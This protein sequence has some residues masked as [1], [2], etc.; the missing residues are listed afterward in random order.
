M[1]IAFDTSAKATTAVG[2]SLTYSI[3]IGSGSD[4]LLLVGATANDGDYVTG[5]TANGKAMT[6]VK[7]QAR[8]DSVSHFYVYGL[9]NPDSGTQNIVVSYSTN[10]T[11]ASGAAAYTGVAQ[12]SYAD[13]TFGGG[14]FNNSVTTQN[15]TATANVSGDWVFLWSYANTTTEHTT[16]DMTNRQWITGSN[17]TVADSNGTVSVGSNNY[18]ITYTPNNGS[19]SNYVGVVFSP[20]AAAGPANLKTWNGVAKASIKTINSVALGS[21]KSVNGI[22]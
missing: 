16:S 21:I 12:T 7:K 11:C 10:T 13:S 14:Q 22:T 17:N 1:A 20:V 5:V 9:A 15:F 3:T 2:T 18:T 4:R 19:Y 6:Q 8:Q